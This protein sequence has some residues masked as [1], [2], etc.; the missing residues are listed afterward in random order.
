[1]EQ[2]LWRDALSVMTTAWDCARNERV[3]LKSLPATS[4]ADSRVLQRAFRA[5]RE[6][7]HPN[8]VRLHEL[9]FADAQCFYSMELVNGVSLDRWLIEERV[10]VDFPVRFHR[11]FAGLARGLAALHSKGILHSDLRSSAV[12][13]R[14]D[15][16]A[17]LLDF[18]FG[19]G[20]ESAS[21][22]SDW[23][24]FGV[25]LG[26]AAHGSAALHRTAVSDAASLATLLTTRSRAEL[27]LPER[28]VSLLEQGGL[29]H[30][31]AAPNREPLQLVGRSRELDQLAREHVAALAEP[32]LIVLD[33]PAGIGKTALA[34]RYCE[35]LAPA[36]ILVLRG[37]CRPSARVAFNAFDGVVDDLVRAAG[38]DASIRNGLEPAA[39]GPLLALFPTFSELGW[40][41]T[42][43]RGDGRRERQQAIGALV[44]TIERLCR[45]RRVVIRID[46]LQWADSDSVELLAALMRGRVAGTMIIGT[47]RT[48]P[49][50]PLATAIAREDDL[51]ARVE[52]SPTTAVPS[53]AATRIELGPLVG[54]DALKLAEAAAAHHRLDGKATAVIAR[55][56]AGHPL[57]TEMVARHLAEGGE[58]GQASLGDTG[59]FIRARLDQ[60]APADRE[61]IDILACARGHVSQ[62]VLSAAWRRSE[63]LDESLARLEAHHWITRDI[64]PLAPHPLG[65]P[66]LAARV[67][68]G[69]AGLRGTVIAFYHAAIADAATTAGLTESRRRQIHF[70]L[71][72]ACEREAPRDREQLVFHW[73]RANEPGRAIVHAR[74]AAAVVQ[75]RLDFSGAAYFYRLALE[76]VDDPSIEQEL[77]GQLG[78]MLIASGRSIEG[79]EYLLRGVGG[80]SEHASLPTRIVA[81]EHLLRGGAR[82]A[83]TV[84]MRMAL[85][86]VGIAWRR[87]VGGAVLSIIWNRARL[88]FGL[89]RQDRSSAGAEPLSA[90]Q[91]LELDAMWSAGVGLSHFD[92]VR[93]FDFQVRH[94]QLA[95]ASNDPSHMALALSTESMLLAMQGQANEA[96]SRELLAQAR[97][98]LGATEARAI[99]AHVRAMDASI[100]YA[101]GHYRLA[102]DRALS[103]QY[104]CHRHTFGT[105]WEHSYLVWIEASAWGRLGSYDEQRRCVERARVEARALG[106]AYLDILMRLGPA[107]YYRLAQDAPELAISESDAAKERSGA[108]GFLAYLRAYISVSAHLYLGQ[109]DAA[110]K[111]VDLC[112]QEVKKTGMGSVELVRTEM[113]DLKARSF[114]AEL[115]GATKGARKKDLATAQRSTKWLLASSQA[116]AKARGLMARAQLELIAGR[117]HEASLTFDEAATLLEAAG[118]QVHAA[119]ARIGCEVANG[120]K[121]DLARFAGEH[122]IVRPQPF[123]AAIAPALRPALG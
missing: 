58:L 31:E 95:L 43:A 119:I 92:S 15:D 4:P 22:T 82:D 23:Y 32:R 47:T 46:D 12:L 13:V 27:T 62:A 6:V 63:A 84:A 37:S 73:S 99:E 94:A 24:A 64:D 33:G 114:I 83:G 115:D 102:V 122:G 80:S 109:V 39:S 38:L 111:L 87:T 105:Q 68:D 35:Q 56:G 54:E 41:G 98:Y 51:E 7:R 36:G 60:L 121:P 96:R 118:E 116:G 85:T 45:Q 70:A 89:R 44:E 71:A 20:Q 16:S 110:R 66:G 9:F 81:A 74:T 106:D 52:V 97:S 107:A 25:L 76:L 26:D 1:M 42:R 113:E 5:A 86:D 49:D 10:T 19:G 11:V 90:A 30:G 3:V 65:V 78:N 108:S 77:L 75:E 28:I 57:L 18:G 91:R 29:E 104:F 50:S 120:R 40:F 117:G 112:T 48:S 14:P 93:A 67:G 17:V 2:G 61:V 103:G 100:E 34:D 123:I 59:A 69:G 88:G 53:L 72:Q 55:L 21:T 8:L 79:G 101:F